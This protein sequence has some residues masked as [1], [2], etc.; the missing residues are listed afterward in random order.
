MFSSEKATSTGLLPQLIKRAFGLDA[1]R[2][3]SL[4]RIVFKT[5]E[6]APVAGSF[7]DFYCILFTVDSL[8]YKQNSRLLRA[9]KKEE[10]KQILGVHYAIYIHNA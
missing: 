5:N 1:M 3:L 6:K 8:L 4:R 7:K 2:P 9:P 10:T